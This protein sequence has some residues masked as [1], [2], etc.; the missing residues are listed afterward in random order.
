MIL[1]CY[2]VILN[3]KALTFIISTCFIVEKWNLRP[4]THSSCW[5]DSEDDG[6]NLLKPGV[7][8]GHKTLVQYLT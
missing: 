1:L 2:V 3:H 8:L 7:N 5:I 4:K 6:P